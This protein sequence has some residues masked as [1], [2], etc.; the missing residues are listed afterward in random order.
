MRNGDES[1][2]NIRVLFPKQGIAP[3]PVIGLSTHSAN[4]SQSASHNLAAIQK[5][6][7]ELETFIHAACDWT[8]EAD[9]NLILVNVSDSVEQLYG[10]KREF[11]LGKSHIDLAGK[12]A[13][14][15]D[16]NNYQ[17]SIN[18]NDLFRDVEYLLE[19]GDRNIPVR[20]SGYPVLCDGRVAGYRG[21]AIDISDLVNYNNAVDQANKR[22]VQAIDSFSG[23]FALFDENDRIVAFNDTYRKLHWFLDDELKPG[24]EFERCLRIQIEKGIITPE[25]GKVDEWVRNRVHR[26]HNPS[27]PFEVQKAND[28]WFRVTEQRFPDGSCLKTMEDISE[29]KNVELELRSNEQRFRDFA[30][31]AADWFFEFN[32]ACKLTYLSNSFDALTG[33]FA[34]GYLGKHHEESFG[35]L[36]PA[37]LKEVFFKSIEQRT[38][39]HDL[40]ICFQLASGEVRYFTISGR[41]AFDDENNYVGYR[42][43][44]KNIT[45]NRKLTDKLHL[46]ATVDDLTGL[47]N[48]REFNRKL[49]QIYFNCKSNYASA[50]L[51]FIDLDEFKIVN[52]SEGHAAG[53]RL[54]CEIAEALS[55][56]MVEGDLIGRL[57]GDEFGLVLND[58]TIET[59]LKRITKLL[60][61]LRHYSFTSNG[62]F[63]NVS[64]SVGVV[65]LDSESPAIDELM[66]QIDIACYE[67]KELGRNHVQVFDPANHKNADPMGD[68]I[69]ASSI[70]QALSRDRFVLYAQP[71]S[72]TLDHSVSHY[73]ILVRML[74]EDGSII[75]PIKFIPVA[76]RYRLMTDIDRWVITES[77]KMIQT[78]LQNGFN[79]TYAINLSGKTLTDRTLVDFIKAKLAE[80]S[81]PPSSIGFEITETTLVS[82]FDTASELVNELRQLGCRFSLDDFGSGLSSFCYLKN[83]KVDYLKIDGSLIKDIEHNEND[84][85]MVS[86]IAN[87]AKTLDMK[88]VAEFVENDAIADI[89]AEFEV[90]YLQ[91]YGIGKPIPITD[92][93]GVHDR[94]KRKYTH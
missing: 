76:E 72:N 84:R 93:V 34:S 40:E 52:D 81:I 32:P 86:A 48:R 27:G 30:E 54:L 51:A 46:H 47:P 64:A 19:L 29:M 5:K 28:Q 3:S 22:F 24:L 65:K 82:N 39:C 31:A 20:C 9:E 75:P 90:D 66:S 78:H 56:N 14:D 38:E 85:K 11:F 7:D 10:V 88:S 50:V 58:C 26:F 17:S 63:Y 15:S 73:E 83:F 8:W 69:N 71:I 33:H 42:G 25:A 55:S 91:G 59:G 6:V 35:G 92:I 4:V 68:T 37:Q 57:G 43:I 53:D 41:P 94:G 61:N 70:E 36:F 80:Y 60:D 1:H 45:E 79:F 2:N 49:E 12:N 13:S 16:W 74:S 18:S 23:S 87:L 67:A 62:R 77:C 44:A 89:L 21:T